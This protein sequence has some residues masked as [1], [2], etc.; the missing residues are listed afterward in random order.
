MSHATVEELSAYLDE[1]L[2]VVDKDRVELHLAACGDCRARF[3]G[4]RRVSFRLGHLERLVP[5]SSL[6]QMVARRIA[7]E[8]KK[9]HWLDRIESGFLYA[10]RQSSFLALFAVVIALAIMSVLFVQAVDRKRNAT[11]P[12]LFEDPIGLLKRAPGEDVRRVAGLELAP[13]AEAGWIE[14]RLVGA[15]FAEPLVVR[16]DD[17]D[18]AWGDLL[19]AHPDLAELTDLET[20]IFFEIDGVVIEL[21]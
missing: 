2:A 9:P 13:R 5:P 14:T 20:P 6:D 11:I 12:V 10:Q 18:P 7:L 1:E 8:G 4:L 21:R 16:R 17:T 15:D 3:E 19:A